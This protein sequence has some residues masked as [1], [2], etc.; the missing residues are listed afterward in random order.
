[1]AG[2]GVAFSQALE[3]QGTGEPA[4][5]YG[6]GGRITGGK[7]GPDG[8]R[9]FSMAGAVSGDS[10]GTMQYA[11]SA[12]GGGDSGGWDT[13][14]AGPG[15]YELPYD[16]YTD[17]GPNQP[18]PNVVGV[19]S[20]IPN[21]GTVTIVDKA[22]KTKESVFDPGTT[23]GGDR[24]NIFDPGTTYGGDRENIFD[25]GT[26]YGGDTEH[27][28]NPSGTNNTGSDALDAFLALNNNFVDTDDTDTSDT[29]TDDTDTVV[30]PE[31][32][33]DVIVETPITV[34]TPPETPPIVREPSVV[35]PPSG[36][37]PVVPPITTTN[38]NIYRPQYENY[39]NPLLMFNV[40]N[41]GRDLAP[42]RGYNYAASHQGIAELNRSLQ[43]MADQQR[44]QPG[45]ANMQQVLSGMRQFGLTPTD[46]ENAYYG[47]TTGL[48]TPFSQY[49]KQAPTARTFGGG[50]SELIKKL[51]S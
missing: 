7:M 24:E 1:M 17:N 39:A 34:T 46:L 28:F 37:P 2:G 4:V 3:N 15:A 8:I 44:N 10:L 30:P 5:K 25:P 51:P 6:T 14:D 19:D 9:R 49:N 18:T 23:Y 35:V 45:G 20:L 32:K 27:V 31:I 22:D 29:D 50:I 48:N 11:D 38:R 12:F 13:L 26:T 40:S 33:S 36:E 41:Y 47:R 21:S 16:P 43:E 42:S